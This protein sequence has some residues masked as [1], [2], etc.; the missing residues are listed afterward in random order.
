METDEPQDTRQK[1]GHYCIAP[2]CKNEFYRVKAKDK[3]IHFHKLPLKRRT[4]LLRW[5]VALKRESPPMGSDSKVC[6]KHFLEEDYTEER[7]FE[8]GKLV[9][10]RTNRLKPEAAPSVFSFTGYNVCCTDRPTYSDNSTTE[11]SVRRR[12][13]ALKPGR[14]E[15]GRVFSN[16][17]KS[18]GTKTS[19]IF[20]PKKK[21]Y[22]H[23]SQKC[24][25]LICTS[26][27][28]PH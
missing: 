13:R 19:S 5:L 12:E 22:S 2:G 26:S 1:G 18:A 14:E 11:A 25:C 23:L 20:I 4:V 7:I 28:T 21:Q 8:S 16:S 24:N 9:V 10:C 27:L 17:Q 15:T 3:T 6:S